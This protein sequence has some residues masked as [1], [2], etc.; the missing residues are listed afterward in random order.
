[1]ANNPFDQFDEPAPN[2]FDQFDAPAGPVAPPRQNF[3]EAALAGTGKV[4]SNFLFGFGDE[5]SSALVGTPI[6]AARGAAAGHDL[7]PLSET[8]RENIGRAYLESQRRFKSEDERLSKER[9]LTSVGLE[10][11]G[12]VAGGVGAAAKLGGA[13]LINAFKAAP[14]KTAALVGMLEGAVF[15]AGDASGNVV[16]RVDD[17][18]G[19]AVVGGAGGPLG[20]LGGRAAVKAGG[21]AKNQLMKTAP[22]RAFF[23]TMEKI[24]EGIQALKRLAS[25]KT[26]DA[27]DNEILEAVVKDLQEQGVSEQDAFEAAMVAVQEAAETRSNKGVQKVINELREQGVTQNEA[28]QAVSIAR[29][30][31]P[32]NL[33]EKGMERVMNELRDMGISPQEAL[34]QTRGAIRRDLPGEMAFDVM[35]QPGV[36]MAAGA[37]LRGTGPANAGVQTLRDRAK[38]SFSVASGIVSK[39]L[40][41]K[42]FHKAKTELAETMK[43][44]AQKAYSEAHEVEIP[45]DYYRAELAPFIEANK[46]ALRHAVKIARARS[47]KG[48]DFMG[49]YQQLVNAL[50]GKSQTLSSRAMSLFL[51]GLSDVRSR[52][53]REGNRNL[54]SALRQSEDEFLERLEVV[55]PQ[56]LRARE[57]YSS[58]ADVK[59]A[60]QFGRDIFKTRIDPEEI[61]EAYGKFT[62]GEREAYIIGAARAIRDK[63][64]RAPADGS[65]ATRFFRTTDQR[66]RL[67]AIFPNDRVYN[68]FAANLDA[69]MNQG[70][71]NVI[72]DPLEG[73]QTAL[74][75]AAQDQITNEATE[76]AADVAMGNT[77][78]A[79]NRTVRGLARRFSPDDT[80][81]QE[82]IA[83]ILF[84]TPAD[85]RPRLIQYMERQ[86]R[87]GEPINPRA[88]TALSASGASQA[89]TVAGG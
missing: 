21:A 4:A 29:N 30:N 37:A 50:Q 57:Q 18:I 40:S 80:K 27:A 51:E 56:L 49:D 26:A 52:A 47:G 72:V 19:G 15:G 28:E 73:S 34:K 6:L 59:D 45:A 75:L 86:A 58:D 32:T 68:D 78:N 24:P 22:G 8:G 81:L 64:V 43:K 88:L 79:V 84:E 41:G 12:A 9:P 25:G 83:E 10:L 87:R 53:W 76:I 13:K 31:P 23:K 2:P 42:N 7:N 3:G 62:A 85:F 44:N 17:T 65:S 38:K 5:I 66:E 33:Q 70:R 67:R 39:A 77:G 60:L 63:A 35:G 61:A 48:G 54:Y 69:V 71:A 1:M 46:D 74:R 20:V 36:K 14:L 16:E 89:A 11:G 82:Q 55:N